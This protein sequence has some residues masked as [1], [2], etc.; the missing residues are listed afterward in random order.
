[1][2]SCTRHRGMAM[3]DRMGVSVRR[4]WC[5]WLLGWSVWVG[6]RVYVAC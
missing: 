6:R 1:M 2:Q 4:H 3:S 5:M